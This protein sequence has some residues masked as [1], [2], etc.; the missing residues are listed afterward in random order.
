MSAVS[1]KVMIAAGGTGGHIYPAL[2]LAQELEKKYEVVWLSGSSGLEAKLLKD[3]PWP[4]HTTTILPLRGRGLFSKVKALLGLG[5]AMLQNCYFMYRYK[6]EFVLVTGGYVG[7]A[8]AVVAYCMGIKMYVC[9]QNKVAGMSNRYLASMATAI[10]TAYP[11]VF[12]GYESKSFVYGNPLRAAVRDAALDKQA[13]AGVDAV[14][15]QFK[16]LILGGSHGAQALNTQIP[17]L[18]GLCPQKQQLSIAHQCGAAHDPIELKQR[19]STSGITAEVSAF[20]HDIQ[21]KYKWADVVIARAG[22][23]TISEL[24]AMA[25]PTILIPLPSSQDQHQLYNAKYCDMY[26]AA[27]LLEQRHLSSADGLVRKINLLHC[28]QQKRRLMGVQARKLSKLDAVKKIVAH[29]TR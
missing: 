1:K 4:S 17:E 21:E 28:N 25:L 29:C 26:G 15:T 3:T 24:Q 9:E 16:V 2:A 7:F 19:Y 5:I 8:S 10:F 13:E 20:W 23:L 11:S 27:L 14:Q 18:L 6:P 22:A 12:S